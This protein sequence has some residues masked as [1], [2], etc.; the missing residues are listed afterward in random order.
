MPL[1][2]HYNPLNSEVSDTEYSHKFLLLLFEICYGKFP[3]RRF[4]NVT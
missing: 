1:I 3:L 2:F 4:I